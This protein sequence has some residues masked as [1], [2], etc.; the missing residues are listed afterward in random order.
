MESAQVYVDV[1]TQHVATLAKKSAMQ[2]SHVNYVSSHA[3]SDVSTPSA[4]RNATSLVHH[5]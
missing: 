3:Q 5:V 1:H 2:T 4:R